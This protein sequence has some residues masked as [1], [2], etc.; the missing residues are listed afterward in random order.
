MVGC[1]YEVVGVVA[2]EEGEQRCGVERGNRNWSGSPLVM[3]SW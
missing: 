1:G 2:W 3:T